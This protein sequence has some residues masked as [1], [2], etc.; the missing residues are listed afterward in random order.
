MPV[1]RLIQTCFLL[2]TICGAGVGESFGETTIQREQTMVTEVRSGAST[3]WGYNGPKL[4]WDGERFYTVVAWGRR[5]ERWINLFG[6]ADHLAAAQPSEQDTSLDSFV[7][8]FETVL[9]E[10]YQKGGVTASAKRVIDRTLDTV[11]RK[12]PGDDAGEGT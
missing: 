3:Y 11:Q 6:S 8:R 4:V 9:R 2:A 5:S 12:P 10:Q 1:L 7:A